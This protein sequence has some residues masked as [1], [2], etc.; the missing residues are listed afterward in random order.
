MK[1]KIHFKNFYFQPRGL[2]IIFLLLFYTAAL[3]QEYPSGQD[4]FY[5]GTEFHDNTL[6]NPIFYPPFYE[7]GMNTILQRADT[8]TL[9]DIGNYNILAHNNKYKEDWIHHYTTGYYSKWEAE[10]NQTDS[11]RVG[12]KHYDSF[13]S[14]FGER[15]YWPDG[16]DSVL[17]W[18]TKGLAALAC[19]L[20]YGPHYRQDKRYKRWL[21][22]C[23]DGQG[24]LTYTPRFRMALHKLGNVDSSEVVCKIKVVFRYKDNDQIGKHHDV[25]FIERTLKVGDFDTNGGFDDFY[26]HVYPDSGRYE[27]YPNFILHK[28]FTLN[29]GDPASIDYI[30]WESYTGIQFCV[31]WLRE[32]TLCTLYIDYVEVY[33]NNGWN[34]FIEDPDEVVDRC[35][36]YAQKYET[37]DWQN[38]KYWV[39]V[40]EPYSIDCY[41]PI[42]I[43]DSLIQTVNPSNPKPLIVAFNPTWWHTFDVNGEDEISMFYDQ[44]KPKK[45]TLSIN[46]CSPNWS[47]IRYEDFEWMRFNFQRTSA[48]DSNFWF[49]AQTHGYRTNYPPEIPGWCVWRKPKPEELRSMVML[50]LAHGTKG[51]VFKWFHSY[52]YIDTIDG[53]ITVYIDCIVDKFAQPTDLYYEIKNNLAPRLTGKLGNTLTNLIYTSNY[54]NQYCDGCPPQDVT[55]SNYLTLDCAASNYYWHIG[56]FDHKNYSDDKHFLLTNL[57]TVESVPALLTVRND[58]EY[59][60]VS[61]TDIEGG[62]DTTIEYN[63]LILHTE[64][65][66]AGEGKL[67]RVAPV[68]LYGGRLIYNE[69]V[70]EGLTLT[71]DMI[72]ENGAVLQVYNTYNAKANIIVKNGSIVNGENGIINFIDGKRLIIEGDASITGSENGKLQLLFDSQ[73]DEI[74]GIQIKAGGS[75]TISD[76]TIENATIGIESLLNANYLEAEYI[77]FIDCE[78][79]SISIAGFNTSGEF[80]SPIV[81]YC[82]M[83]NSDCG[84]S[85]SNLPGIFIQENEITNTANGI[86]LSNVTDAQIIGNSIV[87][88]REELQGIYSSSSGGIS[89]GNTISGHTVGIHL[90]NS[91]PKLGGN[92]ITDNKYHGIYIGV[93]SLPYMRG[94][95]IGNPPVMYALSGY[96]EIKDNG[97]YYESGGPSDNDGSEIYF[98]DSDAVL[99][100]G[101]NS[102]VDDRRASYPLINTLLL[103]N[104]VHTGEFFTIQA[105]NNFWGDTVYSARF[106]DLTIDYTPYESEPCPV[107]QGSEEAFVMM[108]QFGVIID[109]VYSTGV[110]V[111][112]LSE[113]NMKYA[114]AEEYF[115]TGNLASVLQLY[116]EIINSSAAEEEKYFAY[117]RK[118]SIGK[119]TGQSN[120]FFT[121]LSNTFSTLSSNS[122]DSL[123][124]KRLMQFSTLS[125][126][127]EQEYETAISEFDNI[128]QQNPNTEVAVYAEIDALTTALLIQETDS[129]LQKGQLGKYLIRSS[130]DYNKKVNEILKKHFGSTPKETEKEILPTEY[131]LYQNY[132]NPFNPTTTIKYDLPFASEVSLVIYDILG[133]KVKELVNTKQ[134][135]GRYEIQFNASSL[136]SGV[137]IYQLIAEKYISSKKM[138]LLK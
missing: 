98:Y 120:E 7:S 94:E 60:N 45:I 104:G 68:V 119:L 101:C 26:L 110:D 37:Q 35:T 91:S 78:T 129:T 48:L 12:I 55:T 66:L 126:I 44:A 97:G 25:T 56:F 95:Y 67:Y 116:D 72:I 105:Q 27:Y 11:A 41:T 36:T 63:S 64:N 10:E 38:I 42:R 111:P 112:E 118:Y 51:V 17:C 9:D 122:Q 92:Y 73:Q 89:R 80:P 3:A 8:N 77:D 137:Y 49:N 30:D 16:I 6:T 109:T 114:I 50:A 107:P 57:R 96:N 108:N 19:S 33:D 131:T 84:I 69:Y 4:K 86:Y 43:V 93:G 29:V 133:R 1:R 22:D 90:A 87:S 34:D 58:T 39:G 82:N 74:T 121:Q 123:S 138:I 102:I 76:C 61:F 5:I 47:N 31:D 54:I 134:Q 100:S 125:K 103:M 71:D 106:G 136:A 21:Y 124:M 81:R 46:P 52:D 135:A 99:D 24:C 62:I 85:A 83:S 75:L 115:L 113:T 70:G 28:D 32:D 130:S 79:N 117:E 20:M 2:L 88:N 127:G 18:S 23:F 128:V 53:C 40:D 65:M 14:T 13:G 132:P 15:A 59:K